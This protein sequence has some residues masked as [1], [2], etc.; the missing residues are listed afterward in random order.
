[1]LAQGM[2]EGWPDP[3]TVR[4]TWTWGLLV[5]MA[6]ELRWGGGTW[7]GGT[8]SIASGPDGAGPS[9]ATEVEAIGHRLQNKS[10]P[11]LDIHYLRTLGV[12]VE[13]RVEGAQP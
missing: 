7:D 12:N 5:E 11:P 4:K 2:R 13:H 10:I 1:M 8:H 9:R 6:K 3:V